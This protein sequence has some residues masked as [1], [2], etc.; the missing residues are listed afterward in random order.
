MARFDRQLNRRQFDQ[1]LRQSR[2]RQLI[3]DLTTFS[4]SSHE[5]AA[6]ET[7]KVIRNVRPPNLEDVGEVGRVCRATEQHH[8]HSTPSWVGECSPYALQGVRGQGA[9]LHTETIQQKLNS[10]SAE[11]NPDSKN[12]AKVEAIEGFTERGPFEPGT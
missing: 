5:S 2:R 10:V 12:Y 7:R 3:A 8:Q 6:A 4:G 9:G 1:R 11:S